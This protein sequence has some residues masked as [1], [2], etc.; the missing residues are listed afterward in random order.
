MCTD[1]DTI[2]Y[3]DEGDL[4]GVRAGQGLPDMHVTTNFLKPS[5]REQEA[6]ATKARELDNAIPA[7]AI[8]EAIDGD[9]N[10][11][12]A[13]RLRRKRKEPMDA[14]REITATKNNPWLVHLQMSTWLGFFDLKHIPTEAFR[15]WDAMDLPTFLQVIEDD[16]G[17]VNGHSHEI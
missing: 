10:G 6:Y 16:M 3:K 5:G 7:D 1:Q 17:H 9:D 11:R 12:V 14:D 2:V 8:V 13:T 15:K 4:V